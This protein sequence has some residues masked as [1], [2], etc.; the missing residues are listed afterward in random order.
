MNRCQKCGCPLS[1][2]ERERKYCIDCTI[3]NANATKFGAVASATVAI[4]VKYG[5]K[6][7]PIA[8]EAIKKI[9]KFISKA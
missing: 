1:N 8:K 3:D 5:P 9:P 7:V 6:L 2:L 4:G